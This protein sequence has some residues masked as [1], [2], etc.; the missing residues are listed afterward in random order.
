MPIARRTALATAAAVLAKP[1]I[2]WSETA[3]A[4]RFLPAS[5]LVSL[6]PVWS[7]GNVPREHGN[8][9]YD[10]LFGL[11]TR[12]RPHPQMVAGVRVDDGGKSWELTLRE[13]LWFHDNTPVLARDC[14]AS[15]RRWSKRNPY[16]A[17]L[18]ERTDELSAPSDKVIHFRLKRPFPSLP[19]ALA[20]Q[21]CVIMPERVATT[22]P[23]KQISDPTG[24]GPFRFL[25]N[26]HVTGS[27]WSYAKFDKYV[28][29]PDG[30]AS[31][32][33]GPRI[34]KFDR[35]IWSW[36][37]DPATAAAS[38][39]K[40]EHDWWVNVSFDVATLLKKH[41]D[42]V[43]EVKDRTGLI[44]LGRFNHLQKPFNN[45]AIRRLVMACVNQKSFME[46]VAGA[47]PVLYVAGAGLFSPDTPMYTRPASRP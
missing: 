46:A 26:E 36:L 35:L 47:E 10:Q 11:D 9:V 42:L 37:P 19:E 16:G 22:D 5:D 7:G 12:F 4:L 39:T 28:P 20:Q 33:A 15:I 3:R 2:V 40:G 45:P 41:R 44:A 43:L 30:E 17:S 32:L 24:S 21:N 8:T 6:D 25:S 38:M 14:I 13:G 18:M 23:F 31:F 27:H 29:R 34:A 1:G